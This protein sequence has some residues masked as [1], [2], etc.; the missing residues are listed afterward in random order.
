MRG[1]RIIPCW[2]FARPPLGAKLLHLSSL[3]VLS[4]RNEKALVATR[5]F[6]FARVTG[7][8]PATSPVTGECSNQLSYTRKR[9][10]KSV[11]T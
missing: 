4:S 3:G 6:H 9:G 7:L 5:L 1:S 11:F 2:E 8:E 10:T